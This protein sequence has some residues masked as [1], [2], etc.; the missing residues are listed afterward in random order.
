MKDVNEEK[1]ERDF[2]TEST[3]VNPVPN[4]E[5][6][7]GEDLK[8]YEGKGNGKTTQDVKVQ[9]RVG[10]GA[11]ASLPAIWTEV[12]RN[13]PRRQSCKIKGRGVWPSIH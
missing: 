13:G 2:G 1:V 3:M 11:V 6:D 10:T 7:D 8:E 5:D 4:D 12:D 9:P